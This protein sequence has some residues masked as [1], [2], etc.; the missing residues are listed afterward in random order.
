VVVAYCGTVGYAVATRVA[1]ATII[2]SA[3]TAGR[4]AIADIANKAV[5]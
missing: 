4:I 3:G 1:A 2:I 5:L